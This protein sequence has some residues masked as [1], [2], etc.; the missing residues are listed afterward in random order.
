MLNEPLCPFG[1][2]GWG[3]FVRLFLLSLGNSN[4]KSIYHFQ[5]Y[6]RMV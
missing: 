5:V 3:I 6:K 4:V 2:T 1:N